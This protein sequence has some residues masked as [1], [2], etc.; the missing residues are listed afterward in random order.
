[1]DEST[2]NDSA[3]GQTITRGLLLS[4]STTIEQLT[5][6]PVGVIEL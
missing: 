2:A 3:V 5:G 1:M 6:P 4:R